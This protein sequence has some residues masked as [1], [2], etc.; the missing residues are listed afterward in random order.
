MKSL[1]PYSRW[2]KGR[3]TTLGL[4][5]LLNIIGKNNTMKT[6]YIS[7]NKWLKYSP[8]FPK[9]ASIRMVWTFWKLYIFIKDLKGE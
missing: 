4:L 6:A 8:Y 7:F 2:A 9:N 1:S 3:F 5:I